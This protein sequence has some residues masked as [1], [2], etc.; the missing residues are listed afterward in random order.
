MTKTIYVVT[1][2]EYSDYGINAIFEDKD[3]AQRYCDQVN[4][5]EKYGR[6]G[7][8]DWIIQP[9]GAPLKIVYHLTAEITR[10]GVGTERI[11][12][13]TELDGDTDT[14]EIT[15]MKWER[16]YHGHIG[17]VTARAYS[18]EEARQIL[19]K[20]VAQALEKWL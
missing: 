13:S 18:V 7:I 8:E 19:K 17:Q 16:E 6:Y 12:Q 14:A 3:D 5:T 11:S 2:G 9:K 4:A 15:L 20:G 10:D 1:S